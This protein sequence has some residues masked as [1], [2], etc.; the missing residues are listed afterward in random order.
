MLQCF[1]L[2]LSF[3]S[4]VSFNNNESL[5]PPYKTAANRSR[6][7]GQ[8]T[9]R[10]STLSFKNFIRL[11]S[12]LKEN[13]FGGF[14]NRRHISGNEL[15]VKF[16]INSINEKH[17]IYRRNSLIY[18]KE[19]CPEHKRV[20]QGF[21]I[22]FITNE[23]INNIYIY[24]SFNNETKNYLCTFPSQENYGKY[25]TFVEL[26]ENKIIVKYKQN[27]TDSDIYYECG[28][29]NHQMN[30][31]EGYI[32]FFSYT[33]G[34]IQYNDLSYFHIYSNQNI[35][36]NEE[37]Y[38]LEDKKNRKT[39]NKDKRM[40]IS[41]RE[42]EFNH[43]ISTYYKSQIDYENGLLGTSGKS[44]DLERAFDEINELIL[45]VGNGLT[46]D[47]LSNF[48][49]ETIDEKINYA[50]DKLEYTANVLNEFRDEF[51]NIYLTTISLLKG[52]ES[53]I[54]FEMRKTESEMR[55]I[56]SH[57]T[58]QNSNTFYKNMEDVVLS[59]TEN[60]KNNIA[61]NMLLMICAIEAVLY[62]IFIIHKR[63]KTRGFK[64]AD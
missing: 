62:V 60:R 53:E 3:I 2:W 39:L 57:V 25:E 48:I 36:I 12:L 35:N 38:L 15:S 8:Y 37:E 19:F 14:C 27:A 44:V 50:N 22:D 49:K 64:K 55:K 23:S 20:F 31:T 58:I 33:N 56:L 29:I 42:K 5:V 41:K 30:M 43:P 32:S 59:K 24:Y 9:L 18:S 40:I 1:F 4:C 47:E 6:E 16:L 11:N 34:D 61:N 52:I 17:H 21:S 7:I 51:R 10:G 63:R 46:I 13:D 26:N 45:S 28:S 54:N